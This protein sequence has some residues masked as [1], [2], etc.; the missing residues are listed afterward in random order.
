M[1]VKLVCNKTRDGAKSKNQ[2]VRNTC[3]RTSKLGVHV[4]N[5]CQV[6]RIETADSACI[7]DIPRAEQNGNQDNTEHIGLQSG[8][9]R[10]GSSFAIGRGSRSGSFLLGLNVND[11]DQNQ[12]DNGH[13]ACEPPSGA[14]R[15]CRSI[16]E[17]RNVERHNNARGEP[18]APNTHCKTLLTLRNNFRNCSRTNNGNQAHANAFDKTRR[19]HHSCIVD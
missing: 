15:T 10:S 7:E 18:N 16:N 2:N 17:R 5:V 4:M 3:N 1:Q 12:S 13:D 8:R 19:K 9:S 11:R 14:P 6:C